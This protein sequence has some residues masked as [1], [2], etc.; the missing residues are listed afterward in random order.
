MCN[1]AFQPNDRAET[2][3]YSLY[4]DIWTKIRGKMK[5]PVGLMAIRSGGKKTLRLPHELN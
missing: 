1:A 4:L 3:S 5:I 2:L